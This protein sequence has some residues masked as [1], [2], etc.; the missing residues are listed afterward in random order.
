MAGR[1]AVGLGILRA[2]S[3]ETMLDDARG[4]IAQGL[5]AQLGALSGSTRVFYSAVQAYAAEE[6]LAY[7]GP[8]FQR[9]LFLNSAD[10]ATDAALKLARAGT[11]RSE[12]IALQGA[13]GLPWR[14]FAFR[15]RRPFC[16]FPDLARCSFRR[17][18]R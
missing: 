1:G 10:E 7:V 5:K 6:L 14:S 4:E 17:P 9:A 11:K 13:W 16:R 15:P 3:Y 2:D 12:L 8:S 18:L